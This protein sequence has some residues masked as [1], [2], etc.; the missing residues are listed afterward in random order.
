M[1]FPSEMRILIVSYRAVSATCLHFGSVSVFYITS[2][3]NQLSR[4]THVEQCLFFSLCTMPTQTAMSKRT[5]LRHVQCS[6]KTTD[7]MTKQLM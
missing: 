6:I 4:I 5:T 3:S 2:Q 1:K 7:V